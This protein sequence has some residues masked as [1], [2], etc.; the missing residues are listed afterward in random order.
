MRLFTADRLCVSV[1]DIDFLNPN[2]LRD[3]RERGVRVEVRTIAE[4]TGPGSIY[5]S[6]SL[7]VDRAICRF[8]LLES[9]PG[10]A[11]R[12]HW[13]PRMPDGEPC[14]REFDPQ[15]RTDP[16]GFLGDRL[17]DAVGLLEHCGADDPGGY[18]ADAESLAGTAEAIL[19]D[20]DAALR[21]IRL[22]PWPVI[23]RRDHRG[24]PL[25]GPAALG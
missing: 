23:A 15:L 5:A 16:I 4:D 3:G 10:A 13:H 19:A 17:R 2:R 12:M 24:M 14:P 18:A 6:R 8:D 1:E 11:D 20:V 7:G 21:R 25:T 9:G 22:E